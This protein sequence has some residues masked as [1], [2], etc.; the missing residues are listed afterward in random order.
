MMMM[1]MSSVNF[2]LGSYCGVWRGPGFRTPQAASRDTCVLPCC[3]FVVV[4]VLLHC[5]CERLTVLEL[6]VLLAEVWRGAARLLRSSHSP[7][8]CL[9]PCGGKWDCSCGS[10][11]GNVSNSFLLSPPVNNVGVSYPYPE[12]YLHIPDLDNVSVCVC[13]CVR[14]RV[15]VHC[16]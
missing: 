6:F 3:C 14:V 13:V 9:P 11:G 10:C 5:C 7:L 2:L 15:C 16:L 8:S 4:V 12:Y 1:M